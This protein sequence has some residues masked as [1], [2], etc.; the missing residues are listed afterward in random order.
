MDFLVHQE[1]SCLLNTSFLLSAAKSRKETSQLQV[2]YHE[3][4]VNS[5]QDTQFLT[6]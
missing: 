1:V 3:S 5:L 6:S 2:Q 4:D